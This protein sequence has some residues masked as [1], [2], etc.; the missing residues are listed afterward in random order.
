MGRVRGPLLIRAS[1][2]SLPSTGSWLI[3]SVIDRSPETV[4]SYAFDLRDYFA[5]L[6]Q[7]GVSWRSVRLEDLGRFVGWLRK[8]PSSGSGA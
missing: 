3:L 5:F 2:S 8:S 4:R 1:R 6:D 7:A